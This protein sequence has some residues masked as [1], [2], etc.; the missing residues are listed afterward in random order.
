MSSLVLLTRC[1]FQETPE[2]LIYH[3]CFNEPECWNWKTRRCITKMVVGI[4]QLSIPY[5]SV[6]LAF[7]SALVLGGKAIYKFQVLLSFCRFDSSRIQRIRMFILASTY[8]IRS[9]VPFTTCTRQFRDDYQ[10]LI[11]A[12]STQYTA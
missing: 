9:Q 12:I 5:I 8:C 2:K 4:P 3:Q 11:V 6:H 10:F 7:D 1:I